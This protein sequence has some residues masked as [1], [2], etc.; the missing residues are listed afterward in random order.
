MKKIATLLILILIGI[1]LSS[2][3]GDKANP[4]MIKMGL[5]DKSMQRIAITNNRYAGRYTIIDKKS[6]DSFTKLI[7]NSKDAK[8]DSKLEP[9]FIF[10]FFDET[11]NVATFKYIASIED[12]KTANLMDTNGRLYR[13]STSI[14]DAFMKRLM[15]RDNLK[16]IP[17][18]YISLIKL[19][20]EKTNINK[21]DTIVVDIS[22]DYVVTRS[23]TSVEQRS[24]LNSIDSKG[25]SIVFP[26]E[27]KQWNYIIKI[28]TSK[29]TDDTSN[30]VASIIDKNNNAT[31]YEI[32]GTYENGGWNYHIKY[33]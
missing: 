31:K 32:V 3:V 28:N 7:L 12:N 2:C 8:V 13:V 26:N 24:I 1:S 21:G 16:N 20:I 6:I 14:E 30:T 23:I 11:K 25:V 10:E 33:K 19:L 18:Y 22:K 15:E 17:V 29:Y 5:K 4:S 27:V 9:D